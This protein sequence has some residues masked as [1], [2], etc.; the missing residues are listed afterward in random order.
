MSDEIWAEPEGNPPEEA[1]GERSERK[2]REFCDA[3]DDAYD[4]HVD[5]SFGD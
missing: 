4:R 1:P 3:A 5:E 2:E